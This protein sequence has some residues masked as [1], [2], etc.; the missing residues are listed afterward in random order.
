MCTMIV[1]K[2]QIE[3]S[4]R[5]PKGWF[6]LQQANVSYDHPYHMPLEHA[7]NIDFVNPEEGLGARI[8]VEL[9][10]ESARKLAEAIMV[11]LQ[12]GEA[13]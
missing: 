12:R 7:L 4:G 1:E 13:P 9:S 8:A 11:A 10:P 6:H 3:G 5:G 2:A